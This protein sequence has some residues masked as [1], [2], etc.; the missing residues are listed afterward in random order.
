M[1]FGFLRLPLFPMA[2]LLCGAGGNAP[3]QTTGRLITG[4]VYRG[5]TGEPLADAVVTLVSRS[6]QHHQIARTAS[7]GSYTFRD[8]EPGQYNMAAYKPKFLGELYGLEPGGDLRGAILPPD[9][10]IKGADFRLL[11]SPAVSAMKDDAFQSLYTSNERLGANFSSGAFSSDGRYLAVVVGDIVSGDPEQAWRYDLQTGELRAITER[12]TEATSPVVR[13]LLWKGN[14]LYVSGTL[15]MKERG[16]TV[17]ATGD[18][19]HETDVVPAE[20][21]DFFANRARADESDTSGVGPPRKIGSFVVKGEHLHGGDSTWRA[22]KDGTEREFIV[23]GAIQGSPVFLDNPQWRSIRSSAGAAASLPSIWRL[24]I[25]SL[26]I[27]PRDSPH[28]WQR[29]KKQMDS[30]WPIACR[31]LALSLRT[32]K[33]KIFICLGKFWPILGDPPLHTCV[34]STF[35]ISIAPYDLGR[36]SGL[37]CKLAPNELCRFA[38]P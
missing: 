15:G 32:R 9:Q 2:L 23:A 16:F 37:Q 7:D 18:D 22:R 4:H 5:S 31:V 20:V 24:G 13:D 10:S 28:C 8:L 1:R 30:C 21:T 29:K 38:K 36:Y 6:S 35:P 12:P 27:F 17:I 11:L 26:L 3:T 14:S 34:S 33:A 19:I 25:L